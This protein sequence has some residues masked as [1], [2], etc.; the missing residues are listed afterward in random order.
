MGNGEQ[1]GISESLHGHNIF[2]TG[3][4]VGLLSQ[5]GPVLWVPFEYGAAPMVQ[6]HG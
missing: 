4:D 5:P 3:N 6:C 2:L 1:L